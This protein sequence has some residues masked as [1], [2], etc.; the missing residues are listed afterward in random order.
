MVALLQRTRSSQRERPR[1]VESES[2]PVM[3]RCLCSLDRA[4]VAVVFAL[5][6]VVVVVV[7]IATNERLVAREFTH[8]WA[9]KH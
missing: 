6:V 8:N 1:L 9:Q 7:G 4:V 5:A 3:Q 2:S